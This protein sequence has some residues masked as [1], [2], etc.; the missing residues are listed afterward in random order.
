M[1]PEVGGV[2]HRDGKT[3]DILR[4]ML[5][6]GRFPNG[7]LLSTLTKRT[8]TSDDKCKELLRQLGARGID[9][10]DG[11]GWVWVDRKPLGQ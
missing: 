5:D 2:R 4:E 9:L 11:P 7:R 1:A 6:D 3:M 8:G 10:K